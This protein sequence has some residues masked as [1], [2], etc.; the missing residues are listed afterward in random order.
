MVVNSVEILVSAGCNVL[1]GVFYGNVVTVSE[2]LVK[3][4][5]ISHTLKT[6][7]LYK[8]EVADNNGSLDL[9]VVPVAVLISS[10]V[11]L[12]PAGVLE[13]ELLDMLSGVRCRT[14][15][16][17]GGKV[18]YDILPTVNRLTGK[19]IVVGRLGAVTVGGCGIIACST[20]V[21][22]RLIVRGIVG[23]SARKV[24]RTLEAQVHKIL[25]Y[26]FGIYVEPKLIE[27]IE[28]KELC[29]LGCNLI[30]VTVCNVTSIVGYLTKRCAAL[31]KHKVEVTGVLLSCILIME[32]KALSKIGSEERGNVCL[33]TVRCHRGIRSDLVRLSGGSLVPVDKG[34]LFLLGYDTACF[35][36]PYAVGRSVV[37]NYY[38]VLIV[39]EESVLILC[40]SLK[41]IGICSI[42]IT[43]ELVEADVIKR[44][45]MSVMGGLIE[46]ELLRSNTAVRKRKDV[47]PARIKS[48][49]ACLGALKNTVHVDP[50]EVGVTVVNDLDVGEG[51][52]IDLADDRTCYSC[53][54]V[55]IGII[56]IVD[57]TGSIILD[58]SRAYHIL[59]CCS[60][61]G[62]DLRLG[63]IVKCGIP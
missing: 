21:K 5:S 25:V 52:G 30:P 16:T 36:K 42:R 59:L 27:V 11:K 45:G 43:S 9:V 33:G 4:L 62:S 38:T 57:L 63:S 1:T 35:G 50:S 60:D 54:S 23:R 22:S 18:N 19:A 10:Y 39:T 31:I 17:E 47:M 55:G 14:V 24:H 26:L 44:N 3:S 13:V 20:E 28:I 41:R 6:S 49:E 37:R 7:V 40:D 8:V 12:C 32:L 2:A 61:N 34:I 15:S 53:G 56:L 29:G 58:N 48:E 46:T 51:L